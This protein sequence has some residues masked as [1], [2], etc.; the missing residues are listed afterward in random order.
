MA[1]NISRLG[2]LIH[3]VARLL[4][5]RFE[6]RAGV[7]GLSAA[8]WRLLVR[9][10]KEEGVT[11]ARLAA[12]LE[13]EPISI[14]RMVDRMEQSGW[15]ERRPDPNDRRAKAIFATAKAGKVYETMRTV[16][17]EV[18]SEAFEGM[19]AEQQEAVVSG[20][21]IMG[22]NLSVGS[23]VPLSCLKSETLRHHVD[24]KA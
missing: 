19:S 7:H 17:A 2:F 23:S 16:A 20:L 15:I 10:W 21:E 22:R 4:R 24:E 9:L 6:E 1:E 14:S 18:Y 13:V 5:S 8:Q 11:Q 3:D 12:L